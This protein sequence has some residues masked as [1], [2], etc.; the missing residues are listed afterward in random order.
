[1]ELFYY[2][3]YNCETFARIDEILCAMK[4]ITALKAATV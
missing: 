2:F 3:V 1:M 4:S